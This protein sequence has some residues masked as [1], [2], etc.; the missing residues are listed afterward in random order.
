MYLVSAYN[1]NLV[2]GHHFLPFNLHNS[3]NKT[4]P[5]TQYNNLSDGRVQN[6]LYR[7]SSVISS[8]L[9]SHSI[10]INCTFYFTKYDHL[11][12]GVGVGNAK[13]D[14]DLIHYFTK[15]IV[16]EARNENI[17]L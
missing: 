16:P 13:I 5:K 6:E 10:P 12:L 17:L 3:K 2:W 9:W 8:Y 4:K 14:S 7:L 1:I 11:I 15:A